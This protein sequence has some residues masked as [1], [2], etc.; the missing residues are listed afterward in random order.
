MGPKVGGKGVALKVGVKAA[1]NLT[2]LHVPIFSI[3][4]QMSISDMEMSLQVH[5]VNVADDPVAGS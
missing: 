1:T 3:C 5:V 2:P 4:K